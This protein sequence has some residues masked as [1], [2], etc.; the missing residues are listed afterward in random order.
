MK[1]MRRIRYKNRKVPHLKDGQQFSDALANTHSTVVSSIQ[2]NR[3]HK[4]AFFGSVD[5]VDF[6][7]HE[8]TNPF[9]FQN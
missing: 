7:V 9:Q 1:L 6:Q 3:L 8:K 2:M 4:A 5:S